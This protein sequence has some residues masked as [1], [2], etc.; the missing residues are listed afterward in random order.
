LHIASNVF[1]LRNSITCI[2]ITS[3]HWIYH[4]IVCI[5]RY[6][7]CMRK[8]ECFKAYL[9]HRC[10]Y[11]CAFLSQQRVNWC[12]LLSFIWFGSTPANSTNASTK[13]IPLSSYKLSHH[14]GYVIRYDMMQP[15]NVSSEA[16]K[17]QFSLTHPSPLPSRVT[18]LLYDSI[19]W[20]IAC[21][22][23]RLA[24]FVSLLYPWSWQHQ[25]SNHL[26]NAARTII[27][28]ICKTPVDRRTHKNKHTDR[29]KFCK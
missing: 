25:L 14:A 18:W 21:L 13:P 4:F 27:Q 26:D 11:G 10:E 6:W 2:L 7:Q 15:A 29:R 17:T 23:L 5:V 8:Y 1:E 24:V 20:T 9:D 16:D 3:Q 19:Q 12:Q 22:V 28:C